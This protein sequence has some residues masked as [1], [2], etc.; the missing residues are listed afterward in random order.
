M[1]NPSVIKTPNDY[2]L[3]NGDVVVSLYDL[4]QDGGQ[5]AIQII[6]GIKI[7]YYNLS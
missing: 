6:E 1:A 2:E 3:A 5:L 7:R 4:D